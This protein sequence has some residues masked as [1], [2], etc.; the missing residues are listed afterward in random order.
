VL[1]DTALFVRDLEVRLQDLVV[2]LAPPQQT[3]LGV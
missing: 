2:S 1:F 3:A